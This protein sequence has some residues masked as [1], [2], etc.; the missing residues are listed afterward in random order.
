MI[1]TRFTEKDLSSLGNLFTQFWGESSQI[2][3]MRISYQKISDNPSYI[4]LAA[5]QEDDL[6]GFG[7]GIICEELYGDCKPFMVIEDLIV[8]KNQRRSG[9]GSDLIQELEKQAIAN[10]CC[11]IIFVTETDRSDAQR[12]YKSLGYKSEPYKGFKKKIES[13]Q[14][15]KD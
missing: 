5:K 8:D 3:K 11:Q 15:I 4:L 13:G 9:I 12:F 10:N 7:M 14:Q 1:I 2:E 6:V